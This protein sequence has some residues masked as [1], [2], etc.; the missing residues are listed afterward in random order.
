MRA[1]E[2]VN[3]EATK[4]PEEERDASRLGN[5][6]DESHT[7]P[8]FLRGKSDGRKDDAQDEKDATAE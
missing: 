7:L 5:V 1:N 8:L 6:P 4:K 3:G 2:S